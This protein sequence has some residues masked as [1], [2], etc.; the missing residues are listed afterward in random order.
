VGARKSFDGRL[1]QN[2]MNKPTAMIHL[3]FALAE[4][5]FM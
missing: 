1:S 5:F 2:Q 4:I 3:A